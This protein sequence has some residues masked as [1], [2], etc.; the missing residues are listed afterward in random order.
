MRGLFLFTSNP[1]GGN[2]VNG[3]CGGHMEKI[4]ERDIRIYRKIKIKTLAEYE[5]RRATLLRRES[6]LAETFIFNQEVLDSDE[7]PVRIFEILTMSRKMSVRTVA[8]NENREDIFVVPQE[9][10]HH[11]RYYRTLVEM[12]ATTKSRTRASLC[13]LILKPTKEQAEKAEV[14]RSHLHLQIAEEVHTDIVK[15]HHHEM[16]TFPEI[17]KYVFEQSQFKNF[18]ELAY[19]N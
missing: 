12:T 15:L 6:E 16:C 10:D 18:L 11:I 13:I 17:A 2:F 4:P 19:S 7:R 14:R 3:I 5:Q 1:K 9:E 8:V